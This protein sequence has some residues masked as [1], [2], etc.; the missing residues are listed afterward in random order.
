M[1]SLPRMLRTLLFKRCF[2]SK[3]KAEEEKDD[4]NDDNS[5]KRLE[6]MTSAN[7]RFFGNILSSS[8]RKRASGKKKLSSFYRMT[9]PKFHA[10]GKNNRASKRLVLCTK[11]RSLLL[12]L[13]FNRLLRCHPLF[14][15]SHFFSLLEY[16]WSSPPFL[17]NFYTKSVDL[18]SFRYSCL[19]FEI[20]KRLWRI[21]ESII[22]IIIKKST[23]APLCD[24][25]QNL[26]FLW[27]RK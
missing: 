24:L 25:V 27:R 15:E 18:I 26:F 1:R 2:R 20:V 17:W 14:L 6:M 19:H 8:I 11:E 5:W 22:E 7:F 23:F 13:F 21:K 16:D 9:P 10:L 12:L 4:A 3:K